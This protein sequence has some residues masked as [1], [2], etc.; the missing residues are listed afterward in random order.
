MPNNRVK[1]VVYLVGAGATHGSIQSVGYNSRILMKDLTAPLANEIHDLIQNNRK[2]EKL[3]NLV[4]DIITNE[5]D[6]EHII[7][8][9]GESSSL[10]HRQFA[11]ELR[12]IFETVL[13]SALC[14][15]EN[16]LGDDRF[17]L[18]SAMLDMYMVQNCPEHLH[19]ILSLNYDEYIEHAALSIYEECVDFGINLTEYSGAGNRL[20]LLKLHGSFGWQDNWPISKGNS[21]PLWI[22]P[23]IQKSKEQYPFNILWGSAREMLNCDV[24][25]IIGCKLSPSDW[26]LISLLF[27]TRHDNITRDHPYSVEVI[28]HPAHANKLQKQFPY[29]DVH[30][31]LEIDGI[32][33][34]LISELIRGSPRSFEDLDEAEK[35]KVFCLENDINWFRI[36]LEQMAEMFTQDLNI[37]SIETV[38]GAFENLLSE[39]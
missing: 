18:Y 11:D 15:I 16:D 4:N 35:G 34:Q 19:G 10:I 5:T 31:I 13:K 12:G 17:K 36:W 21:E 27:T 23:G 20:K 26:D 29:L 9:L 2:F 6:I 3:N 28:D 30:S 8:F 24:L 1:K 37:T 33:K 32:G 38:A 25:R 14:R 39:N 22:P 7:T